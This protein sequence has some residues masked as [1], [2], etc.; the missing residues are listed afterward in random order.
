MDYLFEH[1]V[2]PSFG[3]LYTEGELDEMEYAHEQYIEQLV[4]EVHYREEDDFSSLV[5]TCPIFIPQ[6]K[7]TNMFTVCRVLPIYDNRDAYAGSRTVRVEGLPSYQTLE[8]A[9]R[10]AWELM[11]VED[12][13]ETGF[14][15]LGDGERRT[16]MNLFKCQREQ[17]RFYEREE[18]AFQR[19]QQ[20][21]NDPDPY[22]PEYDAGGW[23]GKDTHYDLNPAPDHIIESSKPTKGIK[24]VPEV[25]S[26]LKEALPFNGDDVDP[27]A[28]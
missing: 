21:Q 23:C 3:C 9:D 24:W 13:P 17:A 1:G 8:M 16:P 5:T 11:L 18:E 15:I 7:V 6:G 28:D 2:D 22:D 20:W 26:V 27:F 19:G 4:L 14:V 25:K 12:D 10:K